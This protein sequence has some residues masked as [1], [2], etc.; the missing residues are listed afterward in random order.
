MARICPRSTRL[1][2]RHKRKQQPLPV[3]VVEYKLDD[4]ALPPAEERYRLLTTILDHESAPGRRAREA[5]QR[6]L[7]DRERARR[8]KEPSTRPP[9]RAAL[10]TPRRR[11]PRGLRL[12]LHPLR[13]P[14]PDA[15]RRPQSQARPGSIVVHP[16]PPRRPPKHPHPAGIFPPT[17]SPPPTGKRSTRSSPS[18]SPRRQRTN[19]RVIKRKM[20]DWG[21]KRAAHRNG[22]QPTKPPDQ[23]ITVL[24]A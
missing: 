9:R 21:A 10:Q 3:R 18:R 22:P 14:S 17:R 7:G 23:A 19:P 4:P 5:L 12:P 16:R 20:S 1:P 2:D 11:L 15:R 6:A 8:A 13:D 24:A